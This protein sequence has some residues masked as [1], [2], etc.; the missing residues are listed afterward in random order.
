MIVHL[1]DGTYEL[2][3]QFYGLR[4]FSKGEDR[5]FGAVVNVLG[6]VLKMIEDGATHLG[7]ATDHV[8]ESFRNQ[9]WSG[10]K[11][12]DGIDAALL[13]QFH[14]LERALAAMGVVVWP[15]VELEADDALASAAT[16]AA[17]DSTVQKVSIWSPDKDLSQCVR[18]DRIVQ[19]D[20]RAKTIRDEAAVRAKFGVGPELIA[21]YLALVGDSAD[22]YPGIRGIGAKSAASMLN[23][24]GPIE[25]FP[26]DALG[27]QRELALLF[28]R[29]ATLRS[30]EP[31]FETIEVLRWRGPTAEF[32]ACAATLGAPKLLERARRQAA[33][34]AE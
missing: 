30:D 15:M 24:Y 33:R 26:S 4:R 23:R 5:P 19:V 34:L 18:G 8:I 27:G 28:K 7:V 9:L 10:Y 21:D 14:P 25:S 22:G 11:T 3:R 17:G 13:A 6:G 32:E 31:L 2:F 29:L 20:A 1:I 16:I 12:G